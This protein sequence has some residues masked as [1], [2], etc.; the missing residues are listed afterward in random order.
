M[1]T[2]APALTVICDMSDPWRDSR[3]PAHKASVS[4]YLAAKL[5]PT[6]QKS[7]EG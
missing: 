4:V 2:M 6:T 3:D 1:V 5:A 7:S